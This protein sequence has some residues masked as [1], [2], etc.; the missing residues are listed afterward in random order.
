MIERYG[1]IAISTYI[2]LS[3]KIYVLYSGF[4]LFMVIM[5]YNV[6]KNIE[7]AN[8][9]SLFLGEKTRLGSYEPLVTFLF[10]YNFILL[11]LLPDKLFN[12]YHWFISIEL[13]QQNYN[14][15]L[16]EAYLTHRSSHSLLVFK[17]WIEHEPNIEHEGYSRQQNHQNVHKNAIDTVLNRPWKGHLFSMSAGVTEQSTA[18]FELK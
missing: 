14:S 6:V 4:L 16:N 17:K 8:T 15:C 18:S 7:L 12:I 9:K 5:L 13:S 11:F 1:T 2:V 10:I 3:D